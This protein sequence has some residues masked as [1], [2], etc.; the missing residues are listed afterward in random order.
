MRATAEKEEV[1]QDLKREEMQGLAFLTEAE[2]DVKRDN[3]IK[4]EEDHNRPY[5][6]TQSHIMDTQFKNET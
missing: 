6:A 3:H 5:N 2:C 4:E 1:P